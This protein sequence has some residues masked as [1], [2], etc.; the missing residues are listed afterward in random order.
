[1]LVFIYNITVDKQMPLEE[2]LFFIFFLEKLK[3]NA[4]DD[5]EPGELK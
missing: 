4:S 1:M 3:I 2:T 5:T